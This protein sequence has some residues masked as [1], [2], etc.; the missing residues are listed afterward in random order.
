[1][2]RSVGELSRSEYFESCSLITAQ[3]TAQTLSD[4]S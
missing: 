1:L 4:Q 2:N 3:N